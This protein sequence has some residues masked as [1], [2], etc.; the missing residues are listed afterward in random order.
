MFEWNETM[1]TGSSRVVRGGSFNNTVGSLAASSR[2]SSAN[3]VSFIGFRVA[4]PVPA[5]LVPSLSPLG[6]A[7]LWS[8]LGIAGWRKLRR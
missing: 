2:S 5:A 8:L 3:E 6:M 7:M 4:S 1:T